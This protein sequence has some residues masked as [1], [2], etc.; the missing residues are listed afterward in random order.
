MEPLVCTVGTEESQLD[1]RHDRR[2]LDNSEKGLDHG[3]NV[4]GVHEIDG[5]TPD[6]F[7]GPISE[8]RLDGGRYPREPLVEAGDRD[9]VGAVLRERSSAAAGIHEVADVVGHGRDHV[10][11]DRNRDHSSPRG[12]TG[13]HADLVVGLDA[14]ARAQRLVQQRTDRV[15]GEG[16]G[17]GRQPLAGGFAVRQ[18]TITHVRVR[19]DDFPVDRTL[20]PNDAE[21][22]EPHACA[23]ERRTREVSHIGISPHTPLSAPPLTGLR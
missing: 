20:V 8:E 22:D 19:V 11:I 15:P 12:R 9:D 4:V 14:L 13:R 3:S 5:A 16:I 1:R 6:H 18:P 21:R 23:L 17:V 10:V 2:V 7:L